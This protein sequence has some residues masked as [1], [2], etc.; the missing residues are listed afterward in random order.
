MRSIFGTSKRDFIE[1]K[2]Y[3][4]SVFAGA[5][6]DILGDIG[7]FGKS[8]TNDIYSGGRGNDLMFHYSGKDLFYGGDGNDVVVS[9]QGDDFEFRGG[10]G[11]DVLVFVVDQPSE[12]ETVMEKGRLVEAV[13]GDQVVTLA[14]VEEVRTVLASDLD[15]FLL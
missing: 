9:Y 3:D 12:V 4:I 1:G 10:A 13:L 11:K 5:G 14:N 8:V 15:G 2:P 7:R 6:N